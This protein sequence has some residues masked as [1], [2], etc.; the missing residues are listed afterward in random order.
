MKIVDYETFIR[1]PP[2]TIFAPYT[3]FAYLD[4]FKIKL[5][6]GHE[7]ISTYDKK[8]KYMFNGVMPLEPDLGNFDI[9]DYGTYDTEMNS[10]DGD[11][12]DVAD[13]KMFAIL[14]DH[15]IDR[16][17]FALEWAQNGCKCDF[18]TYVKANTIPST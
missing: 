11:S 1:M 8:K 16:L 7:Y 2:G 12:N 5:D 6:C 10:Y 3:P 9:C 17:I 18:D 15:E 4:N 14:E 13:Y